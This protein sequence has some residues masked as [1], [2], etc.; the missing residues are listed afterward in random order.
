MPQERRGYKLSQM[1][2]DSGYR[3]LR[4]PAAEQNFGRGYMIG[5]CLFFGL[6]IASFTALFAASIADHKIAQMRAAGCVV[7]SFGVS[8]TFV[9]VYTVV[10]HKGI[11]WQASAFGR[12]E[13]G[14]LDR[15]TNA[16]GFWTLC[17]AGFIF[18]C[19]AIGFGIWVCVHAHAVPAR[20]QE[21]GHP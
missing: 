8:F 12:M 1:T 4:L 16:I 13:S 3:D 19:G 17:A 14:V 7:A 9:T 2:H 6:I 5:C 15:R 11:P 18:C 20:A 21:T 10:T